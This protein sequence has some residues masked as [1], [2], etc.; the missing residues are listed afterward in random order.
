M[1]A[2]RLKT[3]REVVNLPTAP[4]VESRVIA[5][6]R[7]FVARRKP[8]RLTTDPFG[9]LLVR[10]T[11]P[12]KSA[13]LGRPILFAAHMDH[14]GFTAT[15]MLDAKRV[16]ADF[17]GWV[18]ASYF[19]GERIQFF[20]GGRWI[21]A[22]IEKV[23]AAKPA[24]PR[25]KK[26]AASASS[27]RDQ[28]PPQGVIARCAAPVAPGSPGMWNIPDAVI[29]GTQL[30]TRACDDLAG[31]AGILCMLD[32]ICRRRIASPCFAFFTRAEEVGFAGALAAVAAKTVPSNAV[33]VAVECSK[34][35]TGVALG[36]GPILRVGDKASVF[37]P[38]ATAYCQVVAEDLAAKEKSFRFQRKLMDGGTCESTAYCHYGYDATGICLPLGNYH[39]MNAEKKKIAPEFIDTRDFLNL[40]TWFVALA[41]SPAKMKFDGRHPGLHQRLDTLLRQHR[42]RL[43]KTA[44]GVLAI[45]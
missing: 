25:D 29:R 16:E 28:S 30:H 2:N 32:E 22:T 33:I 34:A 1:P 43:R 42:P 39:N 23:I 17:R 3:L 21:P 12:R 26:A 4:F 38:A 13:R 37:T 41:E 31:L 6:I 27:F 15:R 5:Y 36:D 24:T 14:P 18:S 9:N 20:S 45:S 7:D 8:L 44:R 19:P 11:P 35:I 40:V 10:Y